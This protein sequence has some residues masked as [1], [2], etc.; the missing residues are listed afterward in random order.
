MSALREGKAITCL[1]LF[2]N[3]KLIDIKLIGNQ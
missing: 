2:I 1:K 3:S